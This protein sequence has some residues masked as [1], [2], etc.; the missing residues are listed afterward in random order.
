MSIAFKDLSLEKRQGLAA[1]KLDQHKGY[2]PAYI[3]FDNMNGNKVLMK[4]RMYMIPMNATI[5]QF[6]WKMRKH[7]KLKPEEAMFCITG[8]DK[9]H[10]AMPPISELVSMVYNRNKDKDGFLYI[11]MSSETTFGTFYF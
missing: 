9:K 10:Y 4:S 6:V 3:I 2:V 7:V 5:G 1:S 11:K 8:K